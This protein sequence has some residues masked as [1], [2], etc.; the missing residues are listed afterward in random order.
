MSRA[1]RLL[2]LAGALAAPVVAC[3]GA[4][5]GETRNAAP[6]PFED[7]PASAPQGGGIDAALVGEWRIYSETLFYDAGGSSGAD[8]SASVTRELLLYADGAWEFGTS[9]GQWQ[10]AE[11]E[12]EDWDRWGVQAYGPERR[13]ALDGWNGGGADGPIEEYEDGVDFFWVIYRVDEPDPGTVQ[14]KFGH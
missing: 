2:L 13:I 8:A 4:G 12:A 1:V 5:D 7:P 14:M 9:S 3:G 11:A 6:A 10:V